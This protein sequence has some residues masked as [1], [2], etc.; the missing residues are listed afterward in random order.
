[1]EM[2]LAAPFDGTVKAVHVAEGDQVAVGT[3]LIELEG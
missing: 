3:V 2:P 1:M